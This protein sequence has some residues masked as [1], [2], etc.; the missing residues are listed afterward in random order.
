MPAPRPRTCRASCIV[1]NILSPVR[2]KSG[3]KPAARSCST[4]STQ[5]KATATLGCVTKIEVVLALINNHQLKIGMRV[6]QDGRHGVQHQTSATVRADECRYQR[7][8]ILSQ[9]GCP[10]MSPTKPQLPRGVFAPVRPAT[11]DAAVR[12]ICQDN[13][14]DPSA[15]AN[16]HSGGLWLTPCNWRICASPSP[17]LLFDCSQCTHRNVIKLKRIRPAQSTHR[18]VACQGLRAMRTRFHALLPG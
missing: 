14:V 17:A 10:P 16:W 12:A 2:T 4:A 18:P 3:T 6:R 9:L 15:P 11:S 13:C 5:Q 7:E 8:V 1:V